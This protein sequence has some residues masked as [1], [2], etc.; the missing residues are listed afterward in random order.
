MAA[1]VEANGNNRLKKKKEEEIGG[2]KTSWIIN[3]EKKN[4]SWKIVEPEIIR[5]RTTRKPHFLLTT[6]P[7]AAVYTYVCV[8][9]SLY[10]YFISNLLLLF[11]PFLFFRFPLYY[12]SSAA[13]SLFNIT[14]SPPS[15]SLFLFLSLIP[16]LFLRYT[17]SF[18]FLSFALSFPSLFLNVN[19]FSLPF[20]I[21]CNMFSIENN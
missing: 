13:F 16:L 6:T 5:L 4:G 14:L 10:F 7:P 11:L 17:T 19:N 1:S 8:C 21:L 9:L 12:I 15:L 20:I 2:K 18:V 3:E